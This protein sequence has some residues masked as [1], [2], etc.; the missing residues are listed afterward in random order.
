M[1]FTKKQIAGFLKARNRH[2]PIGGGTVANDA[3]NLAHFGITHTEFML[4]RRAVNDA[5]GIMYATPV[6]IKKALS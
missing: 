5:F 2:S 4:M 3:Y 1:K 6:Q